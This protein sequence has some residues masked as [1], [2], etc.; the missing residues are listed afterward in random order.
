MTEQPGPSTGQQQEQQ[1]A[2]PPAAQPPAAPAAPA[3]KHGI[4]HRESGFVW[5]LALF[6]GIYGIIWYYQL[7]KELG[8]TLGEETNPVVSTLA[9][10][11][12]WLI[13]VPPFVSWSGTL[14]R[15]REAQ[16]RAGLEPQATFGAGF[17]F[18]LLLSYSYYWLQEQLNEIA[19]RQPA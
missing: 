10:T 17:G 8:E 9:V 6:T 15:V 3:H 14:G 11:L 19:D 5:A 13:I 7:C 4:Q 16:E 18:T 1:P 2:A 12:G